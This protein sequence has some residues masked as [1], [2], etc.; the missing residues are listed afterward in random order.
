MEYKHQ[1]GE[2]Q[3]YDPSINTDLAYLSSSY[4][5]TQISEPIGVQNDMS[6]FLAE[7][8]K[9]QVPTNNKANK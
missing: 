3:A 4:S 2:K 6:L 5:T 7:L 9:K 1:T 8:Y